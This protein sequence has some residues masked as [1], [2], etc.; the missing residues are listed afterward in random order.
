MGKEFL[1]GIL[2]LGYRENKNSL[3]AIEDIVEYAV[4][5]DTIGFSRFWLGEHHYAGV[6][7]QSYTNPEI[8][9]T[10][11]A[12]MT[13]NIRVGSAGSLIS[14][15]PSYSIAS[16]FKMLAN[17]YNGR[18]DFGLAKGIVEKNN[19]LYPLTIN[20]SSLSIETLFSKKLNEII[21]YYYQEEDN[22]KNKKF[23]LPPFRGRVPDMWYLS[24]SY[25]YVEDAVRFKLNYCRTIFHGISGSIQYNR[26]ELMEF[27]SL[28]FKTHNYEPQ[29]ALAIAIRM[30]DTEIDAMRDIEKTLALEGVDKS[31]AWRITPVTVDSLYSLLQEYQ[32]LFGIDE[33]ILYDT[34]P[35]SS[36]KLNN[37]KAIN[38]RFKT[39]P[40]LLQV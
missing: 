26:E 18:I 2:D 10:L 1:V 20:D 16:T 28:F 39:T 19:P 14:L 24:K 13:Q 22:F 6:V 11:I 37:L 4:L 5:A 30:A 23:A 40:N 25:Q 36:R 9:V 27:K 32:Y 29:V 3:A 38:S 35:S 17:L 31:Q 34:D 21:D 7:N 15:Y 8:L 33:F 12:G